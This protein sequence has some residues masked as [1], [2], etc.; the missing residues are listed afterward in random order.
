MQKLT[1]KT[2]E[3][4]GT[5]KEPDAALVYFY[6]TKS[7]CVDPHVSHEDRVAQRKE[8]KAARKYPAAR[9]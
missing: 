8:E 9:G 4:A 1:P 3:L 2:E 6:K 7:S 5:Q